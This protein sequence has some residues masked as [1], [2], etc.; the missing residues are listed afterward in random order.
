MGFWGFGDADALLQ[1]VSIRSILILILCDDL[2]IR[3]FRILWSLGHL[4]VIIG[5][6]FTTVVVLCQL[7]GSVC[8]IGRT[9][10]TYRCRRGTNQ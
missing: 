6:K 5:R 4:F 2:L 9:L 8:T 3:H 7:T 10:I 1:V